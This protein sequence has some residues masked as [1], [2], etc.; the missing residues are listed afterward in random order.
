MKESTY[1]NRRKSILSKLKG[2]AM[3]LFSAPEK[4]FSRDVN[5]PYRQDSNINYLTGIEEPQVV[6]LLRGSGK[7]SRSIL[8]IRDK[9]PERELWEGQM[10]G[11]RKAKRSFKFDQVW[12]LEDLP[13]R[14]PAYLK[15]VH[16][17]HTT[18]GTNPELDEV[19]YEILKTNTSPATDVPVALKDA[20]ALLSNARRVKDREEIRL[21][22]RAVDI[23]V[24]SFERLL[25]TLKD[26][27]SELHAAKVLEAHFVSL[28]AST[29][30]FNTIVARGKNATCL[31]HS[32]TL[33]ALFKRDLVLIDAGASYKGYS[34]DITRTV[35]VSGRFS[36][37]QAKVYDI[38]LSALKKPP[39]KLLLE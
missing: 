16:T 20:R 6:L 36:A 27:T 9:D 39:L 4:V 18:I 29:T 21:T 7:G 8:F 26:A 25:P 22:K 37:P 11:L 24:R 17:L 12:P 3:L 32:P 30:A 34:A 1:L 35:P 38:V 33:Q 19:V 15:G 14:L 28:G 31:H 2:D 10:I 23:T 13:H 5:Y